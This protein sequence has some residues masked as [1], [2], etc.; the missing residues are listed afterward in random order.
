[1]ANASAQ[2]A[3]TTVGTR[4]LND[5]SQRFRLIEETLSDGSKVFAVRFN[6]DYDLDRE[7]TIDCESLAE[8]RDLLWTLDHTAVNVM[9]V[10]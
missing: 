8:A 6:C 5:S 9:V 3:P 10:G 2:Q 1:M 7:V 4:H